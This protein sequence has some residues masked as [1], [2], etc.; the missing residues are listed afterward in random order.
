MLSGR[1]VLTGDTGPGGTVTALALENM[2]DFEFDL[3]A[4]MLYVMYGSPTKRFP[5]SLDGVTTITCV[6]SAGVMT[7]T[8]S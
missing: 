3:R 4:N 8:V 7:L 6:I 2:T 5:M 1:A